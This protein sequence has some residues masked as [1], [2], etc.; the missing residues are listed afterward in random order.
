MDHFLVGHEAVA[1]VVHH[2]AG[3]GFAAIEERHHGVR[4]YLRV[5]IGHV[6]GFRHGGGRQRRIAEHVHALDRLGLERA[7]VDVAPTVVVRDQARFHGH[8]PGIDADGLLPGAIL[9]DAL[10]EILPRALEQ[11]AFGHHVRIGVEHQYLR[12]RL[13]LL[14]VARY[15]AGAPVRAWRTA[16][17]RGRYR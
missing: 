17:R 13:C 6:T 2:R 8:A 15:L 1:G 4:A 3:I 11:R 14:E 12:T 7:P 5:L 9:D 10:V 16:V